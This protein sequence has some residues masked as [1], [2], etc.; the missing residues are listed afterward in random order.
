M[1]AKEYNEVKQKIQD[2]INTRGALYGAKI[3]D[4]YE[5]YFTFKQYYETVDMVHQALEN[6]T[7]KGVK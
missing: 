5:P 6:E 1:K 3:R 7:K 2:G 4:F